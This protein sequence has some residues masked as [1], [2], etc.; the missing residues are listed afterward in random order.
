MYENDSGYLF[1]FFL[2]QY[3]APKFPLRKNR[4]YLTKGRMKGAIGALDWKALF[5]L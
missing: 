3:S 1:T 2:L 5:L 4:P